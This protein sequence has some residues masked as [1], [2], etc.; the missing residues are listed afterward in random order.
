MSQL[1]AEGLGS[2]AG[3]VAEGAGEVALVGETGE[4]RDFGER[5]FQI[6]EKTAS[7]AHAK[8]ARVFADALAVKAA[9]NAR[10]MNRVNP[11]FGAEIVEAERMRV[12]G[13]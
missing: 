1:R 12:F 7:G 4:E 3:D 11:G 13:V 5:E 2:E 9:E 8:A 6:E 10:E